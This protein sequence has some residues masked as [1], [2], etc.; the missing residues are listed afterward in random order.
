MKPHRLLVLLAC[1]A[2]ASLPDA[3]RPRTPLRAHA[4]QILARIRTRQQPTGTRLARRVPRRD[5]GQHRRRRGIPA[6]ISSTAAAT[7]LAVSLGS[8]SCNA[9]ELRSYQATSGAVKALVQGLTDLTNAV[10]GAAAPSPGGDGG[11]STHTTLRLSPEQVREVIEDD[12]LSR[13]YLWT[14][15]L[16]TGAYK[17][18]CTFTD[19]TL[20]FTGVSTFQRNLANLTPFINA[21]VDHP[22]TV[23]YSIRL[24]PDRSKI[25]ANWQMDGRLRLPWNPRIKLD[26][27]TVY[28][29]AKDDG[30]AEEDLEDGKGEVVL[31]SAYDESWSLS[32]ADALLQLVTPSAT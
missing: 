3:H 7:A 14:G 27:Q 19:P 22:K 30:A 24:E 12:F 10:G 31:V 5:V 17:A 26:G 28:T 8:F 32:A 20:T 9:E 1:T 15:E 4:D 29:L 21:L 6:I 11:L 25:V 16:T 13:N 23:L 18:D 2:C